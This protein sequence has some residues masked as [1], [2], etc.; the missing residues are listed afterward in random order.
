MST[1]APYT[2]TVHPRYRRLLIPC[3]LGA[4]LLIVLIAA[5]TK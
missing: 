5:L 4:L 1:L 3:A 2:R